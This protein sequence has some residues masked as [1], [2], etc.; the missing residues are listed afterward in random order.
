MKKISSKAN[1]I[2]EKIGNGEYSPR[3]IFLSGVCLFLI[4]FVLGIFFSPKK[5]V[6]FGSNNGNNN[7]NTLGRDEKKKKEEDVK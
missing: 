1:E 7:T 5:K 2:I 3:E 4:G 6:Q